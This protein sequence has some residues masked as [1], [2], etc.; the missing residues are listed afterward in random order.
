MEKDTHDDHLDQYVRKSFEQYEENPAPDMWTRIQSALPTA[1]S[2][3][4]TWLRNR[5]WLVM[6]GVVLLLA[7]LVGE[8]Y[9]YERLIRNIQ[10]QHLKEQATAIENATKNPDTATET[11][12]LPGS[13]EMRASAKQHRG[14]A[15]N[16][17]STT[18]RENMR[19][20]EKRPSQTPNA[21]SM[22]PDAPITKEP[23]PTSLFSETSKNV[24]Q[25]TL[26]TSQIT[27][28]SPLA[29]EPVKVPALD[30][31][32]AA[33]PM[34]EVAAHRARAEVSIPIKPFRAPSGWHLGLHVMPYTIL[35][36]DVEISPVPGTR[37][38]FISR[39]ESADF[40]ADW[41]LSIGKKINS[42]WSVETGL[43][44]RSMTRKATH[45]PRFRL[46]QGNLGP[47]G[48]VRQF[49]YDLRVYGGSA[50]VTL[51]MEPV[52]PSAPLPDNERVALRVT[53]TETLQILRVPALAV[54]RIGQGRWQAV[55]KAG[56]VGNFILKNQL[57]VTARASQNV[58][59]RL[60]QGN[61][62]YN[63]QYQTAGSFFLGYW[64]SLGS[65][66]RLARH[67]GLFADPALS[68]DFSRK[69]AADRSLPG[70]I[71]FGLN[72]GARFYF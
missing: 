62:G 14:K 40:A 56:L 49:N 28:L 24:E 22:N 3:R 53:T 41:W 45:T 29:P 8:H 15:T 71:I 72:T 68:G 25:I 51:R 20:R 59:L 33:M 39:Q 19:R 18:Q 46:S 44:F 65:E 13:S 37:P 34:L 54:C 63:M 1:P 42:R 50:N 67:L 11:S 61:N 48:Q 21:H 9:Y 16:E 57:D 6:A 70:Q 5:H 66:F 17:P 7:A 58:R 35:E 4:P 52:N 69:D 47:S 31:L 60:L 2:H 38:V 64:A 43:G 26:N 55:A 36:Q 27:P 23:A 32:P 30:P 12:S 10:N